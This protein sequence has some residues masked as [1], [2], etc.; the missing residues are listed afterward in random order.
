MILGNVESTLLLKMAAKFLT[1][2]ERTERRRFE[3][4]QP[5]SK[6]KAVMIRK[7]RRR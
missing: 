5:R 6:S 1:S 4:N 2:K 7:H 3:N